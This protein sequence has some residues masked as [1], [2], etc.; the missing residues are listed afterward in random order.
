MYHIDPEFKAPQ[1]CRRIWR[2]M[3]F[4]Q[5]VNMLETE[6]LYFTRLDL[7]DDPHEGSF[8]WLELAD[9]EQEDLKKQ[10]VKLRKHTAVNCWHCNKKQ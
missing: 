8:S 7:L 1:K 6:S 10:L 3:D 5:F 9:K 4:S 2:Y